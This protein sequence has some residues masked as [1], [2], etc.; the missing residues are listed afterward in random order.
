MIYSIVE[1][2]QPALL[3]YFLKIMFNSSYSAEN[4]HQSTPFP[5]IV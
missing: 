5:A 4:L 3:T 1:T 2:H